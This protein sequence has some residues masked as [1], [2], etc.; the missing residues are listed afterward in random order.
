MKETVQNFHVTSGITGGPCAGQQRQ[1]QDL[2]KKPIHSALH[3][4]A[5]D[6]HNGNFLC[7]IPCTSKP[8]EHRCEQL[9]TAPKL[10]HILMLSAVQTQ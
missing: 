10:Q 8:S 5:P 1:Q 2:H 4:K 9:P 3:T 7:E 6:Q